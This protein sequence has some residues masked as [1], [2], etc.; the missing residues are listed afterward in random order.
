[1]TVMAINN[2][3]TFL[4]IIQ[5]KRKGDSVPAMDL[6]RNLNVSATL[7]K[8]IPDSNRPIRDIQGNRQDYAPDLGALSEISYDKIEDINHADTVMQLLPD[9]EICAQILVSSILSPKDMGETTLTYNPPT[10]VLPSK[11]AASLTNIIKDYFKENY[12][13]EP[14]LQEWL[15]AI[16]FEKGSYPIAVIPENSLDELITRGAR[17]SMESLASVYD[18]EGS[19]MQPI[20]LLGKADVVDL[21]TGKVIRNKGPK[22]LG[23][24]LEQYDKV[25][26]IKAEDGHMYIAME[27]YEPEYTN[28]DKKHKPTRKKELELFDPCI[29]VT[30]NP[31]VLSISSLKEQLRAQT[32][33]Q[34]IFGMESNVD[35]ND[36]ELENMIYQKVQYQTAPIVALKT[37]EQAYRESVGE[38]LILHIPSESVIPVFIPG[39]PSQHVGYYVLLD[40][41]GYPISKESNVDH[42]QELGDMTASG[43]RSM[44]GIISQRVHRMFEGRDYRD[45]NKA[46][47]LEASVKAYADMVEKDLLSR[48]RNGIYG[49][50]VKIGNTTEVFRIMFSRSLAQQHTQILFI[51]AEM[52]TYMAFRYDDNGVGVSLLDNLKIINSLR[53]ALMLAGVRSS[54][55]NSIPRTKVNVKL[56]P[57]DPNPIKRRDQFVHE[58]RNLRSSGNNGMPMGTTNPAVI[59]QWANQ[60]GVEFSWSGHPDIPDMEVDISEYASS[61]PQPDTDLRD[62]M[63]KI[64]VLGIGLTPEVVDSSKG[65]DFATTITHNNLLLTRRVG[66]YQEAY[67]PQISAHIRKHTL[68]SPSI[69]KDLMNI[70][71]NDFNEIMTYIA[72]DEKTDFSKISPQ[73]KWKLCEKLLATFVNKLEVTLP[74][75]NSLPLKTKQEAFEE[76]MTSVDK[77]MEYVLSTDVLPEGV[78]GELNQAVDMAVAVARSHFAREWMM[79]NDYMTELLDLLATDEK[80]E[81]IYNLWELNAQY[82]ESKAKA[83]ALFIDKVKD[84][85]RTGDQY[86]QSNEQDGDLG[87]GD[88][89][90]TESSSDDNGS[91]EGDDF[92]MGGDGLDGGMDDFD[93]G[94]TGDNDNPDEEGKPDDNPDD[95][96]EGPA[97]A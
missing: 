25:S 27:K 76:Y 18:A 74:K 57:N 86:M 2:Q 71:M 58:Y 29:T 28:V 46:R 1:M 89:S 53:V 37:G 70:L 81:P 20:G 30:D 13:I 10:D 97:D 17:V 52:M 36:N 50:S 92:G 68:A 66:Q 21:N 26:D 91:P 44:A 12:K 69:K 55:M 63:D 4:R 65:A 6:A 85:K 47:R 51:P 72:S 11:T 34:T 23:I 90:N 40:D 16:L 31:A 22:G 83:L 77:A 73:A 56:D 95:L 80:G 78:V 84:L 5:A 43:K 49:R 8:L 94:G 96:N 45:Y 19:N 9:T 41:N 32:V 59:E 54:V 7:S 33:N 3:S 82:S 75:P 67:N 93:L 61:V 14:K 88:Y 62:Q 79:K 39:S 38:P 35:F 60:A 24:S 15:R 64:G 48:L 87:G 42:Y